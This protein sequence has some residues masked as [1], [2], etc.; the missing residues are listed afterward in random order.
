VVGERGQQTT[1]GTVFGIDGGG[2]EGRITEIDGIHIEAI[3]SGYLV[4]TRSRDVPGVIGRIGK[5]FESH[6]INISNFHL[7]R[8]APGGEAIAVIQTDERVNDLALRELSSLGDV[9]SAKRV[10]L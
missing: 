6:N 8:Q 5:C 2:R 4:V 10:E 1:S 3:A 9:L 7:G